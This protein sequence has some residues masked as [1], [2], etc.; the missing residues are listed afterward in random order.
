MDNYVTVGGLI[1]DRLK[2]KLPDLLR[3]E[4]IWGKNAIREAS[5]IVPSLMV[6]LEMDVP[7]QSSPDG[8]EHTVEQQWAV[9]L[10]TRDSE[11]EAGPLISKMISALA[12][13]R[14]QSGRFSSLKR[15]QSS[16]VPEWS[17]NGV[18]Y[19]PVVFSTGFVFNV[20]D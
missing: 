2:E 3:I 10:V 17:A 14:P 11:G 19:F 18:L 12:G 4:F 15:V 6:F 13:W 8:R 1:V 20:S 7:G 16:H 5:D 9:V